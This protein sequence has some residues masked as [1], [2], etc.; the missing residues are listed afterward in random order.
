MTAPAVN[1][2]AVAVLDGTV[3]VA[4][5]PLATFSVTD[6]RGSGQGWTLSLQAT[7]FPE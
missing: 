6:A 4:H 3:Q 1:D 7:P 5:A 2:F